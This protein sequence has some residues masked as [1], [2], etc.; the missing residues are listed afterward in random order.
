MPRVH[1]ATAGSKQGQYDQLF[2][3]SSTI[4]RPDCKRVP[5]T[6]DLWD[7]SGCSE[8]DSHRTSSLRTQL[9]ALTLRA[10]EAGVRI[11]R[12]GSVAPCALT[13]AGS[14]SREFHPRV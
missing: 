9:P 2:L 11:A 8:V 12:T 3:T 10:E 14:P 7:A 13:P 1:L 4:A 6:G 5:D